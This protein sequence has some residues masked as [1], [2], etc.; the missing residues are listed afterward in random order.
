VKKWVGLL[1]LVAGIAGL[2]AFRRPLSAPTFPKEDW[3]TETVELGS[4]AETITA[5]GT[6]QPINHVAV[7]TDTS[8]RVVRVFV[9][10]GQIVPIHAPLAQFDDRF[11]QL[12]LQQAKHAVELAQTEVQR[13]E[14]GRE[15]A[16]LQLRRARDTSNR[17][18]PVPDVE[19]A[20]LNVKAAEAA[21][22]AAQLK[23]REAQTGQQLAEHA[24]EM[25]IIRAPAAGV[26]LEKRVVPGQQIGPPLGA[27]LFQM[28]T[29]VEQM[30]VTALVAESDIGRLRVGQSAQFTV[31]AWPD[32]HFDGRISRIGQ[33]PVG[34]PMPTTVHYPVIIDA[35]NQKD[36]TGR[37]W[38][39][40]PG[41]SAAVE[42]TLRRH[43]QVWKLPIA[44]ATVQ[45][46]EAK[47]TENA[48]KKLTRWR[49]RSDRLDWQRVWTIGPDSKPW[50]VFLRTGGRTGHGDHGIND[51]QFIEVIS[52][53]PD[54]AQPTK[55]L[56]VL[57]ATPDSLKPSKPGLKLF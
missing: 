24:V 33:A 22:R 19:A 50:P 15:S 34:G 3:V 14:T 52:W 56:R 32:H 31:N 38:R 1:V 42:F 11:A 43:E 40:R 28:A 2:T 25:T 37:D 47:L 36:A 4:L 44:A 5:N 29:N 49:A 10:P 27:Q 18:M 35:N 45:L 20:E 57:T 13:A 23:V 48:Q 6:M 54:E 26:I 16:L 46:D 7:G 21:L 9:E 17:G 39:L 41:M 8:G 53:D 12:R 51:G 55:G 30:Q